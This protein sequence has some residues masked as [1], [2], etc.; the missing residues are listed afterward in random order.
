M[1]E[2]M[3][4]F[5]ELADADSRPPAHCQIVD[6]APNPENADHEVWADSAYLHRGDRGGAERGAVREPYLGEGVARSAA[7]GLTK[8]GG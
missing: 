1:R 3:F 6:G 2:G 5:L 8:G 4:R 7:H